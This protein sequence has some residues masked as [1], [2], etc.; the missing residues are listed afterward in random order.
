MPQLHFRARQLR[1]IS[2]VSAA[3]RL[4]IAALVCAAAVS[5]G[6]GERP[7]D[8][9]SGLDSAL[10]RDLTLAASATPNV[11]IGDT[12]IASAT[13]AAP[14][15]LPKVEPSPAPAPRPATR[16]APRPA[17][18]APAPRPQPAPVSAAAAEV[19]AAAPA[20]S[21][22]VAPAGTGRTRAIGTGTVLEGPTNAAICSLAQRPGDRFVIS[23]GRDVSG[24]D[25]AVLPAGTPVLVELARVDSATG[26]FAFRLRGVQLNGEF[27]PAEGTV[28][29]ADA[30]V[31]ERKVSKGGSDQ[32]KVITGAIIGGILGRV[33]G[34]GARGAVIGAAG[35]AAAGT[36]AAARNSTIERCL[37]AGA[38]LSATLSAPLILP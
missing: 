38:T 2:A 10:D 31:T 26:E 1:V 11:S 9:A 35:G 23:L 30:N 5:A 28:R 34:G 16:P 29:V 7:R 32:G 36:V 33:I 37:S 20:E 3:T 6:C 21:P 17:T 19:P 15:P 27:I 12:A 18:P 13:D 22:A 4:R 8:R 24:P 25:G 14:A